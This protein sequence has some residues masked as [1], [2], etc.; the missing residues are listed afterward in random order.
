MVRTE[1]GW[2][3]CDT[4]GLERLGACCSKWK[5]RINTNKTTYI[6]FPKS[7]TVAK[8]K[9]NLQIG[10]HLLEKVDNPVYLRV[11]LDRQ[12]NLN[13]HI[14]LLKENSTRRLKIV[15][16]LASTT[17][18]ADKSTLRQLYIE[19]V[20]FVLESNLPL[21]A[22]IS[23]TTLKSLDLV[24]S[25]ALHIIAG[26]MRSAPTAAFFFFFLVSRLLLRAFH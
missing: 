24:E 7:N 17:W 15:K 8:E 6:I 5:I 12:L 14:W 20:H 26:G 1:K 23:D 21:Q 22:T 16:R 3:L 19:Y 2:Y 18:D 9:V 25:K 4:T 11:T 13:E 10:G